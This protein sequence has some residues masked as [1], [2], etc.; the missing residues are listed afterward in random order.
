MGV[1]E[2][3]VLTL[4][5]VDFSQ[6]E[7]NEQQLEVIQTLIRLLRQAIPDPKIGLWSPAGDGGS[8]TFLEDNSAA[9]TTA[10]ALGRLINAH[11]QEKAGHR[12]YIQSLK[13]GTMK[14][15]HCRV[16]PNLLRSSAYSCSVTAT[17]SMTR[18]SSS[19][20]KEAAL[21]NRHVS[22]AAC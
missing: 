22:S 8:F 20:R 6:I 4:D 5:V 17:R 14:C 15:Y 7:T 19:S 9:I 16:C 11:N 21:N 1:L 12:K 13:N 3:I 2:R 10:V 18:R